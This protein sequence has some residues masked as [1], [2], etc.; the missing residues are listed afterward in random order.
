MSRAPI[1]TSLLSVEEADEA[2][3]QGQARSLSHLR[4]EQALLTH[5]PQ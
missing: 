5:L 2:K 1:S 3:E 4:A